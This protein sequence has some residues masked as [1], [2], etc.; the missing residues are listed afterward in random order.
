M[1][2]EA[3]R[4][5]P[6]EGLD[7]EREFRDNGSRLSVEEVNGTV[8][9]PAND[10]PRVLGKEDALRGCHRVFVGATA[11]A[12]EMRKRPAMYLVKV[13]DACTRVDH[14]QRIF[15]IADR[16]IRAASA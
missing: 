7:P 10:Q 12:S 14:D 9:A 11:E 6:H 5:V 13:T 2:G 1:N 3:Y 4:E 16:H 8:V 15:P